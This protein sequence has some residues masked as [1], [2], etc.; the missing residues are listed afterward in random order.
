MVEPN[1]EALLQKIQKVARLR[2]QGAPTIPSTLEEELATNPF[3]RIHERSVQDFT[4]STDPIEVL[5]RLRDMK[6]SL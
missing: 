2:E 6:D 5:K 4:G 3:C 1:N